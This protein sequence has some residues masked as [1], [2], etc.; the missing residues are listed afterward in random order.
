MWRQFIFE[1]WWGWSVAVF[2]LAFT[3]WFLAVEHVGIIALFNLLLNAVAVIP[4]S[5]AVIIDYYRLLPG[6]QIAR[7]MLVGMVFGAVTTAAVYLSSGDHI[8]LPGIVPRTSGATVLSALLAYLLGLLLLEALLLAALVGIIAAYTFQQDMRDF[9][10]A[11]TL[12]RIMSGTAWPYLGRGLLVGALCGAAGSQILA[13]MTQHCTYAPDVEPMVGQIGT[14]MTVVSALVVLLPVW[15]MILRPR[16]TKRSEGTAGYFRGWVMPMAFLLPTLI[17]LVVFLYYPGVQIATLSLRAQRFQ[18]ERFV[19]L[20][21][22]LNLAGD[23]IYRSSFITTLYLTVAVVLLSMAFALVIAVLASQKIRGASIYRT[24]LIWPYA[25]SPVVTGAIFLSL[26]RQSR[27]GLVNHMMHEV[28]G[29]TPNWFTD[30]ALALWVVTFASVWNALGFNI[31]FYIAGL[32]NIPKDLL[33]AAEIDGANRFQRFAQITFP[34][35]SP[36]TF[37]LLVMNVTYAFYG[38]YGAVDTLTQGGPPLGL[39]GQEGGATNILIYKLYQDAFAPGGQVGAAAA[40]SVVLFLL[41][42]GMTLLQFRFVER[43]VTYAD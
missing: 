16:M 20:G 40:Q 18:Q 21:N 8:Q 4:D 32:Q 10:S 17:T 39:A 29:I 2:T 13:Y 28:F 35:L 41:V 19:C 5:I 36:F 6:D 15:T 14:V 31:L 38:I 12:R 9:L 22:Y 27:S 25:L 11:R 26:F 24:L 7:S 37:F 34:L 1:K 33:E 42:A 30:P 23:T 43:R 3:L